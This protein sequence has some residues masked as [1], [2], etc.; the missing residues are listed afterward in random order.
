[1]KELLL[2][3][4]SNRLRKV[5][6]QG[7]DD[8]E[9]LVTLDMNP[10][11]GPDVI[12]DLSKLPLPFESG[13]FDSV[14]AFDVME[15][16]GQQGDWQFFFDQWSDIWRI[17]KPGGLFYGLS[18]HP[19]S[20]WAW[21]DPGHTRVLSPECLIFLQQP[22]YEQVGKTAMTDYRFCYRADFDIEYSNVGEDKQ[23]AWVLR[24]VKP[25]R[26]KETG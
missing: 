6:P 13:T 20:P 3:A 24:A 14:S 17:L 16:I 21:G 23:F 19:T 1:M 7:K 22:Q 4:G 9:G 2:G 15:H 11:H 5:G 18:P 10:A 26:V 25:S 8:W 12:W